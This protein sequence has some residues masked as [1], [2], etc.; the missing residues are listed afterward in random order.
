V[1]Y[2]ERLLASLVDDVALRASGA[3]DAADIPDYDDC[4]LLMGLEQRMNPI[5]EHYVKVHCLPLR[6]CCDGGVLLA[7]DT[8]GGHRREA[9]R[10]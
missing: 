8:R 5:V 7:H 6:S 10:L 3:P 1:A 9:V 2:Q 4:P